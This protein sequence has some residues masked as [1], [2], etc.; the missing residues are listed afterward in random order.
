MFNVL[1]EERKGNHYSLWNDTNKLK[2]I[3]G[4]AS[5]LAYLH[6]H[7]IKHLRLNPKNIFIDPKFE[8]KLTG[9]GEHTLI[10]NSKAIPLSTSTCVEE[11]S[12]YLSPEQINFENIT[13]K[14]DVY[15]YSLVVYEIITN[16]LA[17]SLKDQK[18]SSKLI[19]RIINNHYRPKL[20]SDIAPFYQHLLEKCWSSNIDER[21]SFDEILNELERNPQIYIDDV[22]SEEY[23]SYQESIK[24]FQK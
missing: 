10:N 5:G 12:F 21:P 24:Q 13:D 3:Y 17:F 7:Q 11:N 18:E 16:K 15:S 4:I 6:S 22:N 9:I 23:F 1:E 2:I 20:N 14:S 8:V 19:S